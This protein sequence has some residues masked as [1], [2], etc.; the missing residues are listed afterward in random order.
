M[1]GAAAV[2]LDA[3]LSQNPAHVSQ[4]ADRVF[5]EAAG[6]R[7]VVLFGAGGLGRLALQAMRK[8]GTSP[9]ALADNSTSRQNTEIEGVPVLS[10]QEA[11]MRFPAAL[12]VITIWGA[13]SPHRQAHSRRQLQMLGAQQIMSFPPLFWRFRSA[14]PHYLIDRPEKVLACHEEVRAAF[15][16]LGDDASRAEFV[17]QIALRL[18]GEFDA[19]SPPVRHPQ[20]F[21][22]DLVAWRPNER[23]LDG[24]AF[25]GDS[26]RAW[27][28]WRGADFDRWIAIEPDPLNSDRF[29]DYRTSLPVDVQA[30]IELQQ[31]VLG[32]VEG[33]ARIDAAGGAGASRVEDGLPGVEVPQHTIDSLAADAGISFIKLDIEGAELDALAGATT[34]IQSDRPVLAIAAY[35]RQDHL[36]RV[37][38]AIAGQR[39]D[40]HFVLRPHNEEGWDLVCYAVPRERLL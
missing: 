7:A 10:P 25:D 11:V 35:H 4:W 31:C 22:D 30:R 2:R 20:Y 40:D 6:D 18:S 34:I 9:V 27:L 12:F 21:P 1:V 14:L 3:L 38:L 23:V 8:G 33:T 15:A 39:A 37:P 5:E 26:L 28:A 19:L 29:R 16:L 13:G 24:G 36:W 32:R 17:E